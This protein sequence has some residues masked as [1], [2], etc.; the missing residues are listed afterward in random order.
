MKSFFVGFMAIFVAV[1]SLTCYSG[2]RGELK[3]KIT[4][5]FVQEKCDDSMTYCIE[6][7]N[8]KKDVVTASCQRHST[9]KRILNV[10]QKGIE[11]RDELTIRC[12][13]TDVCNNIGLSKN[14]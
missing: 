6:S 7:Y 3:G 8:S 9:S 1:E 11:E 14:F 10:C 12:C 13:K 2:S 5:S 4:E